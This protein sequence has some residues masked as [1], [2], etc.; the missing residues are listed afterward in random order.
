MISDF[1]TLRMVAAFKKGELTNRAPPPVLDHGSKQIS[2][3][4]VNDFRIDRTKFIRNHVLH[5][6]LMVLPSFLA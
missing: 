1:K 4:T 6:H 2:D 3:D 5:N